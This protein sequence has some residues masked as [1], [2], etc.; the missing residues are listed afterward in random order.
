M[1]R[2]LNTLRNSQMREREAL[3]PLTRGDALSESGFGEVEE[4][5]DGWL[6]PGGHTWENPGAPGLVGEEEGGG[7]GV[8]EEEV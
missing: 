7:G 3:G 2:Y 6:R 4:R 5:R 8:G 1:S